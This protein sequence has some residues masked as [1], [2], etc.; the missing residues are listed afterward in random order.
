MSNLDEAG[1]LVYLMVTMA[2]ADE[3][4]SDSELARIANITETLPVFG[5]LSR[6]SLVAYANACSTQ[7]TEENGI[8]TVLR[9]VRDTLP[10]RLYDTAYAVAVEVASADLHVEQEELVLLQMLRDVLDLDKLVVAAIER[11]AR[12]RFRLASS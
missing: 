7:L 2:A 8:E 6:D 1:A 5:V 11:S 12:A 10:E 4:L 3:K 9:I